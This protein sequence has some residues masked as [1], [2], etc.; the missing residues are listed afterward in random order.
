MTRRSPA[1]QAAPRAP[2]IPT[3]IDSEEWKTALDQVADLKSALSADQVTADVAEALAKRWGTSVRTVWR[4]VRAFRKD[5]GLRSV[6]RTRRGPNPGVGRLSSDLEAVISDTARTWW[7]LTENATSAEIYPAI[8][9]EC[10]ARN[11]PPPSRATVVRRLSILKQDPKNFSPTVGAKLRDRTR[12]VKSA[13]E[14]HRALSVVQIDHTVADVLIVDPVSRNCI[15][16]PTLTVAVDVATR[17]VS[18][19][20]LSLESPSSLQ[21]ALCL[22]NAVS[23]K[24][25]WLS[26]LGLDVEWPVFG[27]RPSWISDRICCVVLASEVV[28][29]IRDE[30][31]SFEAVRRVLEVRSEGSDLVFR[32]RNSV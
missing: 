6:L 27:H 21:V 28:R 18:G 12:L 19:I 8:V 9:R 15:G 23:P 4:R 26:K 5:G 31:P 13:Y 20:C 25:E 24:Q 11:L 17:C 1:P 10:V 30:P 29:L 3:D 22:E 14:V 2:E 16:R 32:S 7:K